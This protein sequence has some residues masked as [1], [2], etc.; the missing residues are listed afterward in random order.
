MFGWK[1]S[2]TPD[3][4][5][6]AQLTTVANDQAPAGV[7]YVEAQPGTMTILDA[8]AGEEF[9]FYSHPGVTNTY[10]AFMRVQQQTIAT[11]LRVS[12]D[13]LT[14]DMNQVNYSSARIRLMGL[15]RIWKQYQHAVMKQQVC[16]PIWRAWLDAAALAGVIDAKDYRKH[17]EEY[18][19]VEWLAQPW[20]YVDP[21][22]DVTTV[23]MEIES[24]L[25]SREAKI[26][27]RGDVPEEVDAA[28]KRDHDRE[29]LLGIVP[30]YGNSRVTETVPPGQNEDLA[31]TEPAPPDSPGAP[32]SPAPGKGKPKP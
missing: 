16:R 24:C 31:G 17:P 19:N 2:L 9:D 1:K 15:R 25:D 32:P 23:R 21:V 7:A 13:Q 4:P 27:A 30:V 26:A 8:N 12:Y 3:D 11:A 29:K 22:K 6:L 28:I 20:E 5:Q 14:G 10:E 18:L